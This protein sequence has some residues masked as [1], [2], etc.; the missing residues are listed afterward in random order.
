MSG[1]RIRPIAAALAAAAILCAPSRGSVQSRT[2][3]PVS[4]LLRVGIYADRG[5]GDSPKDARD[6][7]GE[8]LATLRSID[9]QCR[10][11]LVRS[12]DIRRGALRSLEVL[13]FPGGSGEGQLR[14]LGMRGAKMVRAFVRRGGGYVGI[15]AGA[16]L[17]RS[18]WPGRKERVLGLVPLVLADGGLGWDRG[19]GIV[20]VSVSPAGGELLPELDGIGTVFS[21]YHNGPV[22]VPPAANH[23]GGID[24][25]MTFITDIAR[26]GSAGT[27]TRGRPF[28]LRS[29]FGKGTVILA[30]GH[31]EATPGLRWLLPRMVTLA[32][33]KVNRRYPA[34]LMETSK[35]RGEIIMTPE[36]LEEEGILLDICAKHR[37]YDG[38]TVCGAI[39]GLMEV[40]SRRVCRL[41]PPLLIHESAA[42]RKSAAAA[43]GFSEY[44][45]G[46]SAV[47]RALGHE[48]SPDVAAELEKALNILASGESR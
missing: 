35:I 13:V 28:L 1:A 43:L 8:L 44:F 25:L 11:R 22:L 26:P 37:D 21:H 33:G 40:H 12:R 46:L 42:V 7:A 19:A 15:C 3:R 27:G 38:E 41:L 48:V 30:S 14:S 16:Y 6:Y 31:P 39:A 24:E 20:A 29:R 32:A 5:V 10:A 4:P 47:R 36:R 23:T 45:P 2:G 17:A 18:S 34:S 9:P